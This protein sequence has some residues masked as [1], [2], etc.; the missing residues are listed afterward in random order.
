LL[1]VD[2]GSCKLATYP[3]KPGDLAF[4][5]ARLTPLTRTVFGKAGRGQLI[6]TRGLRLTAKM[7]LVRG[8]SRPS[9]GR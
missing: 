4:R 3:A 6:I 9:K 1:I 5:T 2:S 7:I 8:D